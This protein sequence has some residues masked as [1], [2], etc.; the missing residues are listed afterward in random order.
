MAVVCALAIRLHGAPVFQAVNDLRRRRKRSRVT[1]PDNKHLGS[2]EGAR[3]TGDLVQ[4]LEQHLPS[5]CQTRHGQVRRKP[6]RTCAILGGK[7]GGILAGEGLQTAKSVKRVS[8]I[9]ENHH[10]IAADIVKRAQRLKRRS[11]ISLK[12]L[13]EQL[14]YRSPPRKPEHFQYKG[15]R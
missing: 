1:H 8:D 9:G 15:R 4:P 7:I 13:V 11:G 5:H 10:R 3:R 2:G 14:K 12:D 6:I